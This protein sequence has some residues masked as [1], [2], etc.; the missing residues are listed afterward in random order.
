MS[1]LNPFI[2]L[3]QPAEPL[4]TTDVAERKRSRVDS[5]GQ[6]VIE[7]AQEA[8]LTVDESISSGPLRK[9]VA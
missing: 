1:G 8:V 7:I 2:M 6:R 3:E 9:V 5:G 4:A